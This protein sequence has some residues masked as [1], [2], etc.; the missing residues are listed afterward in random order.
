MGR[1]NLTALNVRKTALAKFK[2]KQIPYTPGWTDIMRDVPP[3]Q[4]LIRQQ[5]AQHPLTKTRTR[6]LPNGKTE[7]YTQIVEPKR[8]KS[9][10]A[11]RLF[12]PTHLKYEEDALRRRFYSD[13]PWE[14]ARPRV[15]LETSGDQ[16]KDADWS[17]G[18]IQPGIPL[19]GESVVQRQLWLLENVPDITVPQSYDI[20]RKEFYTLRRQQETRDRIAAEEARHMGAEFGKTAIQIGMK[21]ENEAYNDWEAWARQVMNEQTQ[22]NAAFEGTTTAAEDQALREATRLA[23]DGIKPPGVGAA[24]FAQQAKMDSRTNRRSENPV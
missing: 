2:T 5:A 21:I 8:P 4:I 22:R 11:G 13:H 10:K 19:S 6:T 17:K 7:Q 18:L 20:A 12:S 24:V 14:L 16:H 23:G 3:A 15:V 1:L 9:A